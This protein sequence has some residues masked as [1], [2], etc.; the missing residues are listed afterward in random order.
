MGINLVPTIENFTIDKLNSDDLSYELGCID[1]TKNKVLRF[2]LKLHNRGDKDLV[3]GNPAERP[4][5]FV[6]GGPFGYQFKEKFYTFILK[7]VEGN[8]KSQG[9]KIAFC[10]EDGHKYSCSNQG[11]STQD[12]DTYGSGL[13][14]Q[15]V[16][17]DGLPNGEYVL[18]AT[19]NAYSLQQLNQ[20]NAP[21]IE[22]D[23]Y[24]DNIVRKR[25]RI[26]DDQVNE[27]GDD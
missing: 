14:C 1:R 3:I 20:G 9:Y 24:D 21:I 11:I 2:T 12:F 22:E 26:N 27:L 8:I 6:Q 7:D 17:I 4:D 18:E 5:I 19:A 23:R 10:L 25:L 16:A 15:F 13:P